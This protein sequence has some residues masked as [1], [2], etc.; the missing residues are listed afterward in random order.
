[1]TVQRDQGQRD[2]G[3]RDQGP[4]PI[5]LEEAQEILPWYLTGRASRAETEAVDNLLRESADLRSQLDAAR[6]QRQAIVESS[7]EIG[8][9]SNATLTK[10]LQQI[11]ITKQRRLVVDEKPGFFASLFGAGLAPRPAM[12]LAFAF[13]CVVIVAQGAMLYR[14]GE[15][16]FT[17]AANNTGE[18]YA[19][20]SAPA[21]IADTMGPEL[22][23]SFRPEVTTAQITQILS[24]LNAVIIDGPKPGFSFVLRLDPVENADQAIARLQS[25]PD[26]VATAQRH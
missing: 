3:L 16:P 5:S 11:E 24:E 17:P 14:A 22:L 25:R 26:L 13:A 23:V 20:A 18:S 6:Q 8:A 10:L 19:T 4:R 9:P 7:D 1:M 12:R 15:L 2:Q 21:S